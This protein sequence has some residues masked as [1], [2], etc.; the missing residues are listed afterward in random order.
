MCEDEEELEEK[1]GWR[2]RKR[3]DWEEKV[4][5]DRRRKREKWD[6]KVGKGKGRKRGDG[7][8]GIEELE[9]KGGERT[10]RRRTKR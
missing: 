8:G 6:E 10:R 9:E 5:K 4:G 1:E 3:E 2:R 7:E